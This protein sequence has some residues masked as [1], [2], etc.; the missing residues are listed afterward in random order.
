MPSTADIEE[1]DNLS[2][3]REAAYS[4]QMFVVPVLAAATAVRW[5]WSKVT[6]LGHRENLSSSIR[7]S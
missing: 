4:A 1:E 3:S 7:P 2:L 5:L 6:S